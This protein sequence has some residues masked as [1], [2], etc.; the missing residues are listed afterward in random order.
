MGQTGG[1]AASTWLVRQVA[2][3]DNIEEHFLCR[4]SG[5][6]GL[7]PLLPH[8]AKPSQIPGLVDSPLLPRWALFL[9]VLRSMYVS[10]EKII[11][12]IEVSRKPNLHPPLH[13]FA[14]V[15]LRSTTLSCPWF[16]SVDFR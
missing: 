4:R 16:V 9:F 11:C 6:V 8:R 10:D 1:F 12:P 13:P 14:P 15:R 3:I 7:F 5:H 2:S